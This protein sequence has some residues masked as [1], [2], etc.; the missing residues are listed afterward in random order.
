MHFYVSESIKSLSENSDREQQV[1]LIGFYNKFNR[2]V[3][4]REGDTICCITKNK[5]TIKDIADLDRDIRFEPHDTDLQL[6][7][8]IPRSD[9]YM[10]I[11]G[12]NIVPMT[13]RGNLI[14]G[15]KIFT[16]NIWIEELKEIIAIH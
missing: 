3:F 16:S 6:G 2:R 4:D 13:R 5:L 11:R 14:I 10:T 8:N 15:E 12:C 1:S 7:H 9:K